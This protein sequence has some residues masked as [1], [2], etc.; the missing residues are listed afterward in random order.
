MKRKKNESH[1]LFFLLSECF[2]ALSTGCTCSAAFPLSPK[3]TPLWHLLVRTKDYVT[4]G[5]ADTKDKLDGNGVRGRRS[6][7]QGPGI[8]VAKRGTASCSAPEARP[9]TQERDPRPHM[10]P[11]PPFLL[12]QPSGLTPE[13]HPLCTFLILTSIQPI[14]TN[15]FYI[16][17]ILDMKISEPSSCL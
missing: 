10:P 12:G 16:L 8:F 4:C 3:F 1:Y 14:F 9:P 17:G 6:V 15:N 2:I 7:Q 5:T 11:F 13:Y